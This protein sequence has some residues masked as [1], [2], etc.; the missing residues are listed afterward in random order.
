MSGDDDRA[1]RLLDEHQ[2]DTCEYEMGHC[3]GGCR[4]ACPRSYCTSERH[5]VT[6]EW[7]C[8]VAAPLLGYRNAAAYW[9][10]MDDEWL[11]AYEAN[12]GA[13]A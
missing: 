5:K 13:V 1:A 3:I 8:N 12:P 2:G 11:A 6:P 4:P 7:P 9:K 10:A